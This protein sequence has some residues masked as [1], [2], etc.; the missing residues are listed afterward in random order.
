M[1]LVFFLILPV[2]LSV[3]L[4]TETEQISDDHQREIIVLLYNFDIIM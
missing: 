4:P 1:K 3:H 2:S